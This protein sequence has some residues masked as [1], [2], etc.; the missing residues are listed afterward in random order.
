MLSHFKNSL[1]K[2]YFSMENTTEEI[3]STFNEMTN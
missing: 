2:I 1:E 3:D